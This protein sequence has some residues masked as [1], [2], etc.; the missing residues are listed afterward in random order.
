M[1]DY[2]VTDRL[3]RII[4]RA[5][6][7]YIIDEN[8]YLN[9]G[10]ILIALLEENN[11]VFEELREYLENRIVE[12]TDYY[13]H[14]KLEDNLVF[15][16]LFNCQITCELNEVI[17]A[18]L[19]LMNRYKQTYLN[20]G[21]LLKSLIL[22]T[23][24]KDYFT[25]EDVEKILSIASS[26]R[27]LYVNL[28][29]YINDEYYIE[30]YLFKRAEVLDNHQLIDYIEKTFNHNWAENIGKAFNREQVSVFIALLNG[31]IVGFSAYDVVGCNKGIFGP[32]GVSISHRSKGIG[33]A[34]LDLALKDMKQL[35]YKDVIIDQ[36]G[37]IEFYEKACSAK[38]ENNDVELP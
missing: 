20:E 36:A 32:M 37:P 35:G 28:E 8:A 13:N 9:T 1:M 38:L 34:L 33:K 2:K 7:N 14:M 12:I 21:H 25:G 23:S 15:S 19:K 11:G 22:N 31:E 17:E 4:K 6:D 30:G 16:D 29:N 3:K 10:F 5:K 24:I 26:S 18:S 27:D